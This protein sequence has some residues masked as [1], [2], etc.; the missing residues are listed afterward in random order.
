VR[1]GIRLIAKIHDRV[2]DTARDV[3]KCEVA[4]FTIG[5]IETRCQLCCQLEHEARALGRDLAKARVGHFCY[6]ALGA[7]ADPGAA[8][9]L[10]VEEAHLTEELSFVQVSQDHLVAVFVLDHD[11]DRTVDDVIQN[12]R[13]VAG[14]NHYSF[15]RYRPYAA[16]A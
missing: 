6:L 8:C 4:E 9:R 5:A 14:V 10:F 12:I 16:I 7:S 3:D 2:S 13:Q 1:H 11:F 15:L